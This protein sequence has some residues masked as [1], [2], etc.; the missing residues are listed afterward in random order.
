M[1]DGSSIGAIAPDKMYTRVQAARII[2]RSPDTLKRW[3]KKGLA[4][5]SVRMKA[6]QLLVW[7]YTDDDIEILKHVASTC[8]PGRKP[9]GVA[10]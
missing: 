7:L 4:L 1:S 6:G 9:K 2:G 5:P 3:Q 10:Q 8:K